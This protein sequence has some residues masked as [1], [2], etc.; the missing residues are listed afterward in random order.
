M[1]S[2]VNE[3]LPEASDWAF[4]PYDKFANGDPNPY[5]MATYLL[6]ILKRTGFLNPTSDKHNEEAK[7]WWDNYPVPWDKSKIIDHSR[8]DIRF[9]QGQSWDHK[10]NPMVDS[11]SRRG[12][13][14]KEFD[15]AQQAPAGL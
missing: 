14:A 9:K 3:S 15:K 4:P 1:A 13:A 12:N 2:S 7:Q 8:G 10:K 11:Q 5:P 6:D